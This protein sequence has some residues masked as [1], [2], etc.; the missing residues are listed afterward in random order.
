MTPPS[1]EIKSEPTPKSQRP[2]LKPAELPHAARQKPTERKKEK[3]KKGQR[4]TKTRRI[5]NE[6]KVRPKRPSDR[7]RTMFVPLPVPFVFQ[8]SASDFS[9]WRLK[10]SLA[11]R[12]SPGKML[13]PP[14][15]TGK[16]TTNFLSSAVCRD[17]TSACTNHRRKQQVGSLFFK[18]NHHA[19]FGLF[20]Y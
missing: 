13:P 9:A 8:R 14:C 10:S 17:F 2:I 12:P 18:K 3:K 19:S 7:Q 6:V 11:P 16:N 20:I 1:E 4:P 15:V 5:K